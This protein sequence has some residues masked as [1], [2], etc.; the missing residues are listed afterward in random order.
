MSDPWAISPAGP[1]LPDKI[2]ATPE[3]TVATPKPPTPVAP[4]SPD[5][6]E[7]T[8]PEK[9]LEHPELN[10]ATL[11]TP[12]RRTPSPDGNLR[13]TCT[14]LVLLPCTPPQVLIQGG[15]GSLTG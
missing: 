1:T 15:T 3:H 4:I 7:P 13:E 12:E 2:L 11:V 9:I 5:V 10:A 14:P 6:I 8:L